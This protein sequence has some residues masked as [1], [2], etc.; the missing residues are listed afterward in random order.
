M[1]THATGF[2][3]FLN[4]FNVMVSNYVGNYMTKFKINISCTHLYLNNCGYEFQQ[5]KKFEMLSL[6]TDERIKY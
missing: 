4:F 6:N 2:F 5:M 3:Y 1:C